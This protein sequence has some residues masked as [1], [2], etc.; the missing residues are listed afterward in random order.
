MKSLENDKELYLVFL[1][2]ERAFDRV[3]RV[4][5]ESSLRRKGVI[6]CY[7]KEVMKMSVEVL[8]QVKRRKVREN[9]KEFAMRVGLHQGSVLSPFTFAVVTEVA[10]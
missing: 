7:V 6:E 4:L 8:S 3:P 9:S 2:L 5:I 10:W 1:D